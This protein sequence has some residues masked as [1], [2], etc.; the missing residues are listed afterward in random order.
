[1]PARDSRYRDS[2][3]LEDYGL[4]LLQTS[5]GQR[6]AEL[7]INPVTGQERIVLADQLEL[8]EKRLDLQSAHGVNDFLGVKAL[9]FSQGS[10]EK[11]HRH[12]AFPAIRSRVFLEPCLVILPVLVEL[13]GRKLIGRP[14]PQQYQ[15]F[16]IFHTADL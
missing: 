9:S 2:I 6:V 15:S 14:Y 10:G 4:A 5:H 11:L 7:I 12:I 8:S 16:A 13:F 1:M 3:H